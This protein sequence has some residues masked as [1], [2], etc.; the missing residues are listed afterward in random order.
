MKYQLQ[1]ISEIKDAVR[2]GL[3]VHEAS[4]AYRMT[5]HTFPNGAE[6]WL[7]KCTHNGSC[8]GLTNLAGDKLNGSSF[9]VEFSADNPRFVWNIGS[10]KEEFPDMPEQGSTIDLI[11][12]ATGKP[13]SSIAAGWGNLFCLE[14]L[15]HGAPFTGIAD[16]MNSLSK[17]DLS[18]EGLQ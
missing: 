14:T 11:D 16:W 10:I 18:S 15:Q 5:L 8:I 13:V 9:Y 12:R 17:E 3:V 2:R 4:K 7:V 6:Q 1:T